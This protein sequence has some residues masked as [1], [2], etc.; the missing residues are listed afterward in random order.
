MRVYL[1]LFCLLLAVLSSCSTTKMIK[2]RV[3]KPAQVTLPKFVRNITIVNNAVVQPD[4][5]G[6][7][8]TE[9]ESFLKIRKQVSVPSDSVNIILLQALTQFMNEEGFYDKVE[10]H[11]NTLREDDQFL[12]E[13]AIDTLVLQQIAK[14]TN[15]DAILSLDRVVA[16]TDIGRRQDTW[17][18]Y[19]VLRVVIQAKFR[20][21]SK[22]G[23]RMDYPVIMFQDTLRWNSLDYNRKP[24]IT[25]T[26]GLKEMAIHTADKMV[27]MFIP[28]W[29]EQYRLCYTYGDKRV[30]DA[31]YEAQKGKWKDA[32]LIWGDLFEN[33]KRIEKRAKLASNIAL[34]NEMLDDIENALNW[35]NISYELF[36]ERYNS[37]KRNKSVKEDLRHI[38]TF[39][40]ILKN[41]VNEFHKLDEQERSIDDLMKEDI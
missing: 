19:D 14:E 23:K 35:A 34:A 6:H 25:Q 33:E 3:E 21:Y 37:N 12:V 30:K 27:S 38:A 40:K 32:A 1:L 7:T 8:L 5:I 22:E 31:F 18:H 26:N 17:P 20:I 9:W 13:T 11:N 41:R 10:L 15:A 2:I 29:Q 16:K 39:R 4:T 28:F 24:F 36:E